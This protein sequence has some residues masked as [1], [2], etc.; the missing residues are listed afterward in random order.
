M[1]A[2]SAENK[3]SMIFER[4]RVDDRRRRT[5]TLNEYYLRSHVVSSLA[6]VFGNDFPAAH[7]HLQRSP[8]HFFETVYGLRVRHPVHG[9]LVNAQY[10]VAC[11]QHP[12]G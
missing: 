3:K 7:F 4:N 12:G 10:L 11:E 2:A 9:F 1:S 6:A 8:A 5:T